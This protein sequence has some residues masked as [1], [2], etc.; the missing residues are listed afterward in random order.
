MVQLLIL[1]VP[2]H[3]F[4]RV[5]TDGDGTVALLPGEGSKAYSVRTMEVDAFL[6]SRMTSATAWVVRR[7]NRA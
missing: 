7:A 5:G 1:D 6:T 2:S 4:D 3:T